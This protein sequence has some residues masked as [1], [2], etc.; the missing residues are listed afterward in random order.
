MKVLIFVIF[1]SFIR[2]NII[3]SH[4]RVLRDS[5]LSNTFDYIYKQYNKYV[6]DKWSAGTD[7]EMIMY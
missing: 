1:T 2:G 3:S 5:F 7:Y 6:K 4:K